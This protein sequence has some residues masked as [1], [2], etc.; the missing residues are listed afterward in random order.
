MAKLNRLANHGYLELRGTF[1]SVWGCCQTASLSASACVGP[2]ATSNA[3]LSIHLSTWVSPCTWKGA[4]G[5]PHAFIQQPLCWS[6]RCSC[7]TCRHSSPALRNRGGGSCPPARRL[8]Y[9][10]RLPGLASHFSAKVKLNDSCQI[11][12][13]CLCDCQRSRTPIWLYLLEG[14]FLS[15]KHIF[16]CASILHHF[17][18]NWSTGAE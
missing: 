9:I 1:C 14:L 2:V 12:L 18:L 10:E 17:Q 16:I 6:W 4:A 7:S 11:F 15:T 5:E 8:P 3:L 13:S